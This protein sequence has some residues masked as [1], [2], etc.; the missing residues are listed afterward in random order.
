MTNASVFEH[1]KTFADWDSD[2]YHP[3]SVRLYDWIVRDMLREMGASEGSRILDA[4]CGPGVHAIRATSHGCSVLAID[5]SKT[6]LDEAR[7]RIERAGQADS[8]DLQQADLRGL[9]FEDHSFDFVFSWGVIIHIRQAEEALDELIRITRPG[10]SLAL[11]VTNQDAL[12]N[13]IEDMIRNVTG[14]RLDRESDAL[15]SGR[16]YTMNGEKLWVWR[17]D[18]PALT[19]YMRQRGMKLAYRSIGEFSELHRRLPASVRWIFLYLNN[20]AYRAGWPARLGCGNL[21]VFRKDA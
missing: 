1:P 20:L 14:K 8:V 21:L 3:I 2:Y 15:G 19:N 13:K 18:I 10:G 5:I 17:F 7:A 6:M 16:W 12:D 11:Y 4:G 9:A